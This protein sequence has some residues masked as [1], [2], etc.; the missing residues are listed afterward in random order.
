MRMGNS[1]GIFCK[2]YLICNFILCLPILIYSQGEFNNW[3]FGNLAAITFNTIPPSPLLNSNMNA[4][5]CFPVSVSDSSGNLLF[6]S[7]GS[8]VFNKNHVV[9]PNGSGLSSSQGLSMIAVKQLGNDNLYYIITVQD[10]IPLFFIGMQYS[11]LDMNLNGGLGD[12]VPGLKNIPVSGMADAMNLLQATRHHNNHDIWI[13][14]KK[15]LTNQ[16]AAIQITSAGISTNIVLS[17]S[18]EPVNGVVPSEGQLKISPDGTLLIYKYPQ[19]LHDSVAEFCKF[20]SQTGVVTPLFEFSPL[21]GN[22]RVG[23]MKFDFSPNSKMLYITGGNSNYSDSS[24]IFQYDVT[25]TNYSQ[26]LASQTIVSTIHSGIQNGLGYYQHGTNDKLY[27]SS[28]T[29]MPFPDSLGAINNPNTIGI[30]CNIEWFA[31]SL[32]GRTMYRGLPQFLQR[33]KSYLHFSGNCLNDSLHFSGDIW[34]PADTIRWNFGDPPSGVAN[35][36]YLPTPSHLFTAPGNYTVELYVRHND[37]RTDTT[38]R[39]IT[40]VASPQVSLGPDRTICAGSSTSFDAGFCSACSYEWKNLGTGL[41]VGTAQTFATGIAGNYSVKV[42]NGNNCSGYDTVQLVTTP[43]PQVTNTQLTKSICSGES[44]NIA[45]SPSVPG[46]VFHWTTSLISGNITGFSADSGLVINQILVDNLPTAGVVAYSVTP[47]V[48]SCSGNAV[49]FTVTVNPGDSA[50]V[51]VSASANNICAGTP[52]TFTAV[53]TNPGTSPVYQ[54]KVNGVGTGS[55]S[56]VFAYAPA[57]G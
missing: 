30:G 19:Q 26:I 18:N 14:T 8:V 53:P 17:N 57:N 5:T 37:N 55:N 45:L 6:Y 13:I 12:I 41:I 49:D 32:G 15:Y 39:T 38:W 21:L 35:V 10:I 43:V 36:S 33:Y 56:P 42:T 50:K 16:Y 7:N 1:C 48:G 24:Y 3:Y 27:F 54:W 25:S 11:V 31:V 2:S 46:T 20:N 52:V 34:P 40:I 22:Y 23:S 29:S 4:N 47:K 9:M 28:P 44:T 51:S